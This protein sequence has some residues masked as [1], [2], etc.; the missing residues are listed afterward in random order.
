MKDNTFVFIRPFSHKNDQFKDENVIN[1]P[2]VSETSHRQIVKSAF[3]LIIGKN[4]VLIF[5]QEQPYRNLQIRLSLNKQPRIGLNVVNAAFGFWEILKM[6]KLVG[7]MS[8][9]GN[10]HLWGR[11]AQGR[12][13]PLFQK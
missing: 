12:L 7:L 10:T 11:A 13:R 4:R 6:W 9:R 1:Q 8:G 3:S 5:A 2:T